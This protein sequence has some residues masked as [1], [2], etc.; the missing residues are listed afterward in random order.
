MATQA[1]DVSPDQLYPSVFCAAAG[2]LREHLLDS[3]DLAKTSSLPVLPELPVGLVL[4]LTSFKD[5]EAPLGRQFF[6]TV[7]KVR[8]IRKK[9]DRRE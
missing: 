3:L 5:E 7:I 6:S 8:N 9:L 2:V 1:S 4:E